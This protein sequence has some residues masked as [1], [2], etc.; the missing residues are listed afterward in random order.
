LASWRRGELETTRW[1]GG[2]QRASKSGCVWKSIQMARVGGRAIAG[3]LR[4]ML[5][6]VSDFENH[7]E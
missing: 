1:T 4:E 7:G 5:R 2:S 3:G 6:D